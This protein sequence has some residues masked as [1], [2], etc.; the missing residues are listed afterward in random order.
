MVEVAGVEPPRR[1]STF[2]QVV[3]ALLPDIFS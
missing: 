3:Y 2:I 1:T